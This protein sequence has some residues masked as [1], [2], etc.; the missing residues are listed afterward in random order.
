MDLKGLFHNPHA[1][2]DADL[3][4]VKGRL[5]AQRRTPWQCAAAAGAGMYV[6]DMAILKR[7]SPNPYMLTAA[8]LLGFAIGNVAV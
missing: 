5:R 3:A 4:L 1:Y 8:T 7:K 6:L 2:S